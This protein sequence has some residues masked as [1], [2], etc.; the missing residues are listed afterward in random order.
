MKDEEIIYYKIKIR[1]IRERKGTRNDC[2]YKDK[3]W[4]VDCKDFLGGGFA[5]SET[6]L[7]KAF[8]RLK[9]LLWV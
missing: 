8:K 7:K 6:T 3:L 4:I 5:F 2:E 1:R 9:E